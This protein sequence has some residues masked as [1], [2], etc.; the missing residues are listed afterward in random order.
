MVDSDDEVVF[1]DSQD[2]TLGSGESDTVTF[3]EVPAGT[4][5][6][7]EY[8]HEIASEDDA[9]SGEPDSARSRV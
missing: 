5:A 3:E 1:D 6:V 8:T 7:G 9:V 4:L 2:V